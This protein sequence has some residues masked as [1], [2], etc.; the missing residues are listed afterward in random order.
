[1]LCR[2]RLQIFINVRDV[3]PE[4]GDPYLVIAALGDIAR[5]KGLTIPCKLKILFVFFHYMRNL[6]YGCSDVQSN[7]LQLEAIAKVLY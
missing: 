1:M 5:S 7:S 6:L 4:D 2:Q 3:A